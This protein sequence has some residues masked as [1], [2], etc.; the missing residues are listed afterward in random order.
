VRGHSHDVMIPI[1]E[2]SKLTG[3]QYQLVR[4]LAVRS[5]TSKRPSVY[6]TEVRKPGTSKMMYLICQECVEDKYGKVGPAGPSELLATP[7]QAYRSWDHRVIDSRVRL[8][9]NYNVHLGEGHFVWE[10]DGVTAVCAKSHRV[11]TKKCSCG[12]YSKNWPVFDG[13]FGEIHGAVE[14][15]GAYCE[16]DHGYRAEKGR[17]VALLCTSWEQADIVHDI[18]AEYKIPVAHSTTALQSTVWGEDIQTDLEELSGHW[19][20]QEGGRGNATPQAAA[21]HGTGYGTPR[22][23]ACR[24]AAEGAGTLN[25]L[26]FLVREGII[27]KS[28][29]DE[30]FE[31]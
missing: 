2:A 23:A 15:W 11:P 8:V 7:I 10:P 24:V 9:S 22:R 29:V 20:D 21:S 25:E 18:A 14:L 28:N 6:A 19:N 16:G 4:G 3:Q 13:Y 5:L 17:P 1:A 12:L 26:K 27:S 30:L 31:A